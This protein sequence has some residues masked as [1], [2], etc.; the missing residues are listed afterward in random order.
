[1]SNIKLCYQTKN[2]ILTVLA[3][4]ALHAARTSWSNIQNNF[5]ASQGT[6]KAQYG[7]I[8]MVFLLCYSIG[9]YFS[10]WLGDKVN[11]KYLIFGGSVGTI[12]SY[13]LV[14]L[15]GEYTNMSFAL[16][17]SLFAINGIFQSTVKIIISMLLNNSK[18][19]PGNMSVMGHWIEQNGRGFIL[20]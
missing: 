7:L 5:N 12:I 17:L 14:G 18:G 19:W 1:M 15:I 13:G 6:S 3:Y 9:M 11:V 20:V 4:S 10:G 8:N 2:F 16:I